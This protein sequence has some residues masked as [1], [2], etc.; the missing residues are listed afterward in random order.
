MSKARSGRSKCH[1]RESRAGGPFV[2]SAGFVLSLGLVL[3]LVLSPVIRMSSAPDPHDGIAQDVRTS[4]PHAAA[5]CDRNLACSP[6]EI[7]I[8]VEAGFAAFDPDIPTVPG[9]LPFRRLSAPAVDL[10]PPRRSL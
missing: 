6:A 8:R 7:L 10:P 3:A 5:L 2:R 4:A 1:V 9:A